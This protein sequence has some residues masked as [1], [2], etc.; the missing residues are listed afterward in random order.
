MMN[1]AL[2]ISAVVHV[3]LLLLLWQVSVSL[4]RPVTRGYPRLITAT[5][6]AKTVM[7]TAAASAGPAAAVEPKAIS[8]PTA[9]QFTPVEKKKEPDKVASKPDPKKT[10]PAS[11]PSATPAAS[12][13]GSSGSRGSATATKT[14]AGGGGNSIKIDAAEFPYPYYS[15][16][17]QNRIESNWQ[18]PPGEERLIAIVYFKITRSGEIKDIKLEQKSGSFEFDRAAISA[19][20]YASPLPPLPIDYR[21]QTLVVRYEFAANNF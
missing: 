20:T 16:A 4:S 19:V 18:A 2:F 7:A 12:S 5:L 1:R 13:S 21:E 6:V 14:G 11:K 17:T 8:P 15:N 10:L 9:P 3:A